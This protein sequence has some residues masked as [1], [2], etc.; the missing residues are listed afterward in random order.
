[1]GKKKSDSKKKKGA[2]LL[3]RVDRDERDAFV[4]LCDEKDTS[5][6]R[7]IRRFMREWVLAN[8][9]VIPQPTQ[10]EP[11]VDQTPTQ[12][13]APVEAAPVEP[14]AEKPRKSRRSAKSP[15]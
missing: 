10:S 14:A 13:S 2:Q 8:Q 4:A 15:A 7:E 1:M 3:I 9:P 11:P 12:E 6:A 5:A